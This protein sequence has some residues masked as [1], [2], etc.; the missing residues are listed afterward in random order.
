MTKSEKAAKYFANNYNCSQSVFTA[1]GQDF[2]LTEDQCFK[3]ACAFGA[4]MGRQQHTCGAV[5]GALMAIG[6]KYGKGVNDSNQ[7]KVET[8]QKAVALMNAFKQK[9]GSI[10]CKELL[11]GLDMNN[12]ADMKKI[13]EMRLFETNCLGYVKYATELAEEMVG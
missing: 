9:N 7:K 13:S 4:G 1:I 12:D 2:G 5:T 8:Y 6:L 11:N 3:T 10:N